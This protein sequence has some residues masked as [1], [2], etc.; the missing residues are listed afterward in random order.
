MRLT[1]D[2][3]VC[4]PP[5]LFHCFGLVIG[6]LASF[7]HGSSI[8]FASPQFDANKVL[9]AVVSEH[10]TILL[11]VPTMFLSIMDS[12]RT[13]QLIV[14][15]LRAALAAG[16]PV[17]QALMRRLEQE[18]GVRNT[19]IA[20]G[21]TETSP[22]TFM[23]SLE[24]SEQRRIST[25]GTLLPHSGAK[26][27]DKRGNIVP[28]GGRGEICTSGFALQLGYWENA[29]KTKEAMQADAEG[30]LW[31]YTG[32]EGEIDA[33]GY[34]SITGRIK[35][36][37]IRGKR[38]RCLSLSA[39]AET[40]HAGG[41]NIYPIEIEETLLAHPG[42]SEASVVGLPD[43]RYGE[44]VACFLRHTD[45]TI[46]PGA[47]EVAAWVRQTLGRHKAPRHVFW[48][49]DAGIGQDYPK[50]GSGK[51]QKH[52]LKDIGARLLAQSTPWAP[53]AKL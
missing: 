52:I 26:V 6:F 18:M 23:S 42:I 22:V 49:G 30:T 41:E 10:C 9:D 27:V 44:A 47:D 13:K 7:T 19:L 21:M 50:T 31:M 29:G 11:G 43:Q 12:N 20:Y 1:P 34:C 48:I 25:V 28:R 2:D 14:T 32:D 35:D 45:G 8:V 38:S 46:R 53:S 15:S 39:I 5:P 24:D 37:I 4:C 33:E 17:P 16:S 51:H 40:V 36:T 3:V